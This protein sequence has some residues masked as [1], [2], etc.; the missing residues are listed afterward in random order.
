[1]EDHFPLNRNLDVCPYCTRER[2]APAPERRIERFREV[3]LP[4]FLAE[5]RRNFR[6]EVEASASLSLEPVRAEAVAP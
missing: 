2:Q 3:G 6:Y 5:L 1:M 4:E